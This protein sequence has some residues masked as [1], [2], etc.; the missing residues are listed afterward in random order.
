MNKLSAL[1]GCFMLLANPIAHAAVTT[2]PPG[3]A[4]RKAILDVLRIPVEAE[5]KQNVVFVIGKLNVGSGWAFMA[6][7]PQRK[8]GKAIDYRG[9]RYQEAVQAGMFDDNIC[10]LLKKEAGGWKVIR[11]VLG[12]TDVAWDGWDREFGVPAEL[13]R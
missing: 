1:L 10:A 3:S 2:P 4:E 9:T 6:G 5:L 12:A 13:F 7:N 8:D 11:Y